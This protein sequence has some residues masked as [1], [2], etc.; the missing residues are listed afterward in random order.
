MK[1]LIIIGLLGLVG[2]SSR[3]E[4]V[5]P[6]A[7]CFCQPHEGLQY[8]EVSVISTNITC[9]NGT[10]IKIPDIEFFFPRCGKLERP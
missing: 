8:I 5:K 10:Q 3:L 2:C 7:E 1:Y 6:W 9:N 4:T